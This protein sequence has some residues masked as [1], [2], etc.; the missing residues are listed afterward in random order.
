MGVCLGNCGFLKK[1]EGKELGIV[2]CR[3]KKK[4]PVQETGRGYCSGLMPVIVVLCT[5]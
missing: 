2:A 3:K 1:K 5:Q 4:N